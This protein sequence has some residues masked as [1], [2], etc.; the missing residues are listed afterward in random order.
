MQHVAFGIVG[1]L[2]DFISPSIDLGCHKVAGE[3]LASNSSS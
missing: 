3:F 1:K 2:F